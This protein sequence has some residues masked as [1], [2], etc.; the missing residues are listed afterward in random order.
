MSTVLPIGQGSVASTVGE[1]HQPAAEDPRSFTLPISSAIF[2]P[3]SCCESLQERLTVFFRASAVVVALGSV[4][5]IIAMAILQA[6]NPSIIVASALFVMSA[7]GALLAHRN[8]TLL[9]AL[10]TS[11]NIRQRAEEIQADAQKI[12]TDK[13]A[14]DALLKKAQESAEARELQFKEQEKS[15]NEKIAQMTQ[16]MTSMTDEVKR[17]GVVEKDLTAENKDLK[18]TE[19][20]LR[21][22]IATLE[23]T[24]KTLN[25][26]LAALT[27]ENGELKGNV[28][29]LNKVISDLQKK[30]DDLT[31][32]LG[33]FA[34]ENQK[35]INENKELRESL[36]T[37]ENV[38]VTTQLTVSDLLKL[39]ERETQL[40]ATRQKLTETQK[41]LT[42][43][44]AKNLKD[45]KEIFEKLVQ[46]ALDKKF[47]EKVFEQAP[48]IATK[49]AAE[50]KVRE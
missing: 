45:Q 7:G 37:A 36:K 2:E 31:S 6:S 34:A 44:Q 19:T 16:E 24:I 50:I 41:Q 9:E 22:T 17:L 15:L 49:I 25:D 21:S 33:T 5:A 14:L 30:T 18:I 28:E 26:D 32:K 13:E 39:Q 3:E 35:F 11:E 23:G 40:E 4:V 1:N 42:E 12:K 38:A 20:N 27:H 29:K 48:D 47:R 43:A 8:L 10:K 46:A